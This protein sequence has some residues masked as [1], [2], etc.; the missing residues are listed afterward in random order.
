MARSPSRRSECLYRPTGAVRLCGSVGVRVLPVPWYSGT[1]PPGSSGLLWASW[2]E[3]P[4]SGPETSQG[5]Q[6]TSR[7][8]T[9]WLGARAH[10][11]RTSFSGR[12]RIRRRTTSCFAPRL[13]RGAAPSDKGEVRRVDGAVAMLGPDEE[14]RGAVRLLFETRRTGSTAAVGRHLRKQQIARPQRILTAPRAAT[15]VPGEQGGDPVPGMSSVAVKRYKVSGGLHSVGVSVVSGIRI[16][17]VPLQRADLQARRRDI[18]DGGLQLRHRG[19]P[20][21]GGGWCRCLQGRSDP[22]VHGRGAE[23][24]QGRE[25]RV[26]QLRRQR[27]PSPCGAVLCRYSETVPTPTAQ[28]WAIAPV[29]QSQLVLEPG[30]PHESSSSAASAPASPRPPV[31]IRWKRAAIR[32]TDERSG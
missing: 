3:T 29:G 13:W 30:A 23:E 12:R 32:G 8:S 5:C 17:V 26:V 11:W 22:V 4:S 28:A 2:A 19:A 1:C 14:I 7:T 25:R 21:R 31:G 20:S 24:Q 6:A 9:P 16:A 18:G 27:Q 10:L 15:L